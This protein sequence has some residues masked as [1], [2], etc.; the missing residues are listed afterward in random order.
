MLNEE[1]GKKERAVS[2]YCI[3][4]AGENLVKYAAIFGDDTHVLG[5]NGI[6]AVMGSK[7]LKAFVAARGNMRPVIQDKERL[8]QLNKEM[9]EKAMAHP[10]QGPIHKQG[11][12]WLFPLV[13]MTGLL[14]VKNL[15]TNIVVS[16]PA[17]FQRGNYPDYFELRRHPCWA[18][19]SEHSR[20]VRVTKGP[21]AGLETKDPEYESA[22]SWSYL[23]GNYDLAAAFSLCDLT[24]RLGL[25]CTEAGFTVAL[26]IE[27]FEKGIITKKETDGLELTWGNVEAVRTMLHKIARREGFGNILAEG[28]MRAA[29][30]IG[31]EAPKLGVYVKKGHA[32]RTHDARA[33]WSD[34]LDYATGSV[35]T[36]E[37]NSGSVANPFS[38]EGAA[39][40]VYKGKI[41]EFVDS[42]V[43]CM[44]PTMT[45]SGYAVGHLVDLLNAVTGWDFTEEEALQMSLRV[46]NL[47]RAFN[48]RHGITPEV[49]VPSPR[50][51]SAPVDGPLKGKSIVP[52][53]E[54]MLDEYYVRMGWDRTSGKPL[55]DT[56]RKLGLEE[57]IA[58]IW[59]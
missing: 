37:S 18:C 22:A 14:P 25:D 13:A 16:D 9:I 52:Y 24:D 36:S 3:G 53:W 15:T 44:L 54:K 31:G 40:V 11:T 55:P 23:I 43:V 27:C 47:F 32:P 34:I 56:L 38:P 35:G 2:I 48:I 1:L 21:Y 59:K 4:P 8:S 20:I 41:R 5:H 19:P 57:I 7:K 17:S 49:E 39:E 30:H 29:E 45:Y 10:R 26:A 46:A 51:G 58:D 6:G 12:S 50:Y 42:L 28:V 33:R